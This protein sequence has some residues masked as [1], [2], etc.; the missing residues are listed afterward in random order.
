MATKSEKGASLK[1][2]DFSEGGGLIEGELIWRNPR[3]EMFNY[4]GKGPST[5]AFTLD[6]ESEEG[7]PVT[8]MWSVGNAEDWAPSKDGSK[9]IPIGKAA[10]LSKS[11]NFFQ[12]IKSLK[13]AG[14]PEE[15]IEDDV[16]VYE[17]MKCLM[18]RV[19]APERKG[20]TQTP[21]KFEATILLVDKVITLPWEE[22]K[23]KSKGGKTGDVA[24]E[25]SVKATEVIMEVLS[26][27]PK[28]I[29]RMRLAG[30]VYKKLKAEKTDMANINVITKLIG[31][32][33]EGFLESGPWTYE[34]GVVNQ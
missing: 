18:V 6:L 23:G 32:K 10:K 21:K 5:P 20:L 24:D 17:G 2:G 3:F 7:D 28:G 22:E 16:T 33:D 29:D 4:G 11:S 13:D 31:G 19:P 25:N 14:F 9:I 34:K 30:E 15:K 27:N 1:I 8:Q 12:L 26:E